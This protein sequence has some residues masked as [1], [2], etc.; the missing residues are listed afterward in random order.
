MWSPSAW[1]SSWSGS[2]VVT[3]RFVYGCA[4]VKDLLEIALALQ[5]Q[6]PQADE[7][8]RER[9]AHE[10][11]E[12]GVGRLMIGSGHRRRGP[13]EEPRVLGKLLIGG[14]AVGEHPGI[15]VEGKEEQP[16]AWNDEE[17]ER[18]EEEAGEESGHGVP[19]DPHARFALRAGGV[20]QPPIQVRGNLL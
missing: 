16:E 7:L 10:A 13:V 2:P 1:H 5:R 4:E 9:Q 6:D 11:H 20:L 17:H 12:E 18:L 14:E 8:D 19:E 15:D 3:T